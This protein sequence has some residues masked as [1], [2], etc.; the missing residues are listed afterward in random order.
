MVYIY[1]HPYSEGEGKAFLTW[2]P[3]LLA[4]LR[5]GGSAYIF[6]PCRPF[7]SPLVLIIWLWLLCFALFSPPPLPQIVTPVPL[8]GRG[9]GAKKG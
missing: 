7:T 8:G 4:L 6:D 5:T 9:G 3:F 2:D 1:I